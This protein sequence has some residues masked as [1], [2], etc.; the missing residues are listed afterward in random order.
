MEAVYPLCKQGRRSAPPSSGRSSHER[1][2]DHRRCTVDH[3]CL[4]G[5]QYRRRQSKQTAATQYRV[6]LGR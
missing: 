1:F 5:L 6:C 2:H 4:Y 3:I